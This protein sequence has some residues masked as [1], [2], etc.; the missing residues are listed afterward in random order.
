[1]TQEII[2]GGEVETKNPLVLRI[3]EVEAVGSNFMWLVPKEKLVPKEE[4]K[5]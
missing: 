2:H 4:G 5:A 1:V 3:R